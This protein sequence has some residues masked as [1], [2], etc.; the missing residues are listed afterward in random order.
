MHRHIEIGL[1]VVLGLVVVNSAQAAP[2]DGRFILKGH[3]TGAAARG[4][5]APVGRTYGA[6]QRGFT[7]DRVYGNVAPA[8]GYGAASRWG[9]GQGPAYDHM[10]GRAYG[11]AA[12]PGS[13]G[14][15]P[16]DYAAGAAGG[17]AS[18]RTYGYGG[19]PA[20]GYAA[21][22]SD[23]YAT[24][25]ANGYIGASPY[26]HTAGPGAYTMGR[27]YSY[28][29]A[30]AYG[31]GLRG[32]ARLRL[33][34]RAKWGLRGGGPCR[35]RLRLRRPAEVLLRSGPC[36]RL[37]HGPSLQQPLSAGPNLWLLPRSLSLVGGGP[38]LRAGS[39]RR[40]SSP[41]REAKVLSNLDISSRA[42]DRGSID[43]VE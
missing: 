4:Y 16:Y 3:G 5:A 25:R 7:G 19:G 40:P 10:E 13:A 8:Y 11:S 1:G 26:A 6:V 14:V 17:Y 9:Y 33:R 43:T 20:Y 38:H 31:D 39:L 15:P 21:P 22:P 37:R 30:P 41:R 34:G 18:A 24:G 32:R 36:L 12:R 35:P 28:P 2:R 23:G 42:A 29:G 27:T